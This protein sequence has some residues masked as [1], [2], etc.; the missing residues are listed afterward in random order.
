MASESSHLTPIPSQNQ[1]SKSIFVSLSF[2]DLTFLIN[3]PPKVR[4]ITKQPKGYIRSNCDQI[5]ENLLLQAC[6][7]AVRRKAGRIAQTE[8]TEI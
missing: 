8:E 4:H 6:F 2:S 5:T 7:T 3:V 1:V